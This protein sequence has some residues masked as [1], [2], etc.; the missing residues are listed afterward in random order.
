MHVSVLVCTSLT[1]RRS[2]RVHSH[3]IVTRSVVHE[4]AKTLCLGGS[5]CYAGMC[6]L[7]TV[8]CMVFFSTPSCPLHVFFFFFVFPLSIHEEQYCL[9][10]TD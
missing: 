5:N 1:A 2:K 4:S 7:A 6:M 9:Y 3:S 8:V 10:L